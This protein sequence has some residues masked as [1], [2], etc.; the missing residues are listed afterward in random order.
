MD[1]AREPGDLDGEGNPEVGGDGPSTVHDG[2]GLRDE[3]GALWHLQ[4]K[5]CRR[6]KKAVQKWCAYMHR[7]ARSNRRTAR[8]N[9]PSCPDDRRKLGGNLGPLDQ[10][11]D[12]RFHSGSQQYFTIRE[13]VG[14]LTPDG[15]I[16]AGYALC[17]CE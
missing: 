14:P 15:E 2:L 13:V 3:V 6:S 7:D 9:G 16:Y 1:V 11:A 12:D 4:A 5:G 10:S 8:A 17:G